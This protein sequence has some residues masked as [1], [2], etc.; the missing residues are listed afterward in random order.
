MKN[1]Y[2]D[3]KINITINPR[4][5]CFSDQNL[6]NSFTS[7]LNK[8][9][10]ILVRFGVLLTFLLFTIYGVV[11]I[12]TYPKAYPDI[13]FYRAIIDVSLIGLFIYTF[14][15]N[16]TKNLQT[17]NTIVINYIGILLVYLYSFEIE[18]NFVYIFVSSY[19]LFIVGSFALFG[20]KFFTALLSNV[21]IFIFMSIIFFTQFDLVSDFL[22]E[23]LFFSTLC[24]VV[25]NAYFF[26]VQRRKLFLN[27]LGLKKQADN[28]Y[29]TGIYNRRYL[30]TVSHELIKVARREKTAI[31]ILLIDID[32]FKCI[33]DTYG[34]CA[35]DEVLKL[36]AN[37]L[38][39]DRRESDV[40]ARIGGEEFAILLP[41]TDRETAYEIASQIRENIE[42]HQFVLDG[43]KS[44]NI[45]ASIGLDCVNVAT[46]QDL[47][48]AMNKADKALYKA[49]HSGRNKVV[50]G[51][52]TLF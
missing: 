46:D 11:D 31:S 36:V 1:L 26:E 42:Q 17:I 28:D 15:E 7:E 29:L 18:T 3:D 49:K 35:G 2:R 30:T 8:N 6:E 34:H 45:T 38:K 33:N 13:W 19:V 41:N 51:E 27:E 23:I 14:N 50:L 48:I 20:L 25:V 44:L 39:K 24:I 9:S 37:L 12:Y 32:F 22:Y 43:N 21:L 52:A 47:D 5:L 10:V 4:N 40:V 16:Y